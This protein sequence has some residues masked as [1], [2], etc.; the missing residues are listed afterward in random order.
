M[1]PNLHAQVG[2]ARKLADAW[3]EGRLGRVL[4]QAG[5]RDGLGDD[6]LNIKAPLPA[7]APRL[8]VGATT[9]L[10]ACL[11]SS[12]V[13]K[14]A[15][16]PMGVRTEHPATRATVAYLHGLLPYDHPFE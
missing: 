14:P 5:R 1:A 7:I 4:G 12:R 11:R 8:G 9:V 6:F 3:A 2:Q 16:P 13:L 15:F 10:R